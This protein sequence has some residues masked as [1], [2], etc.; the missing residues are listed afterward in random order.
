MNKKSPISDQTYFGK[1]SRIVGYCLSLLK[2]GESEKKL[3]LEQMEK[4]VM[5][6]TLVRLTEKLS[7]EKKSSLQ[8]DPQALKNFLMEKENQKEF[9][10]IIYKETQKFFHDFLRLY[11]S[12]TRS[13]E[14][15]AALG[16]AEREL[17]ISFKRDNS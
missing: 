4:K 10:N 11:L 12:K 17:K 13:K 1:I 8:K 6:K 3:Y 5:A 15:E 7:E 2:E 14:Q 16:Y 9:I